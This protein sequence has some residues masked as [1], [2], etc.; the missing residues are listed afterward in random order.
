MKRDEKKAIEMGLI[1]PG[2]RRVLEEFV[3]PI[4]E[5]QQLYGKENVYYRVTG[6][7]KFGPYRP[8]AYHGTVHIGVKLKWR[9]REH[10]YSIGYGD[11]QFILTDF[12][13]WAGRFSI[14]NQGAGA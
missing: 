11:Y 8:P 1:A 4:E 13:S 12:E 14:F 7:K 9:K 2:S 10:Y 6:A 3:Q 5:L